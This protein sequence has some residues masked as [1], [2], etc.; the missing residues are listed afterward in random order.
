MNKSV[1]TRL[2]NYAALSGSRGSPGPL[3][4]ILKVPHIYMSPSTGGYAAA[5]VVPAYEANGLALLVANW[6]A[7]FLGNWRFFAATA[8]AVAVWGILF[9]VDLLRVSLPPV[10]IHAGAIYV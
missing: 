8:V 1:P 3:P 9:H 4:T 6:V 7:C 5:S 2:V 10:L